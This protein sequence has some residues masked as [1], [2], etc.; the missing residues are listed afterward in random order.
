MLRAAGLP[1]DLRKSQPYCGYETYEFDV[2]DR[3]GCDVYCRY[4]VRMH[5]MEESL[6]IIEQALDRLA[7]PLK[8]DRVMMDDKKIGWPAQLALGP[9]GL[10]NSPDHIAHIM[11]SSMEALIHHFKLVT[12][13]FRV[14]GGPGLRLGRV[15]QRRARRARG[16]RRWHPPL[17]RPL[18]RAV[19]HE[20]AGHPR[21]GEGGKIADVIRRWPRSTRSWEVWTGE[22]YSR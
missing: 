6:K 8:G 13:G 17:P 12:E 3:A 15:A 16:Q 19:V 22:R 7:G 20:P 9:D 1:W 21:H 2:P 10:G 18:P 11:G 14:P 4:L 5:E